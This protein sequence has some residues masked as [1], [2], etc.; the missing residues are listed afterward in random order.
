MPSSSGGRGSGFQVDLG[1]N[2]DD[3]NATATPSASYSAIGSTGKV[4]EQYLQ[5]LGGQSQ[6]YFS[7]SLGGRY[8]DQLIDGTANESKVGYTSFTTS[9][10]TQIAKDVELM[11]SG[12]SMA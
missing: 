11:N 1:S 8:V 10:Q 6:V 12:R 3:W 2:A 7:T 5:S 9:V 4:G